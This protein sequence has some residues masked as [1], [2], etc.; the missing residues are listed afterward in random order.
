MVSQSIKST[1]RRTA[2]DPLVRL[3]GG[4]PSVASTVTHSSSWF[5]GFA[6]VMIGTAAVAG[7][8]MFFALK[9]ALAA[10][11][12]V[13]ATLAVLWALLILSLDRFMVLSMEGITNIFQ[14]T[15]AALPR[16]LLAL[17][18]G[19]V[20]SFPITLQIFDKEISEELV[21]LQQDRSKVI[22]Q[23]M[24][25]SEFKSAL[26]K[27]EE[28]FASN[29]DVRNGDLEI[30]ASPE[31]EKEQTRVNGLTATKTQQ[32]AERNFA[33]SVELCDREGP[34][35]S[36]PADV[37]A[38]CSQKPGKNP[39]W[40]ERYAEL[41]AK[42]SALD[43]TV[44]E[45]SIANEALSKAQANDA[46][47]ADDEVQRRVG[48]AQDQRAEL[49]KAVD[50][51]KRDYDNRYAELR[52]ANLENTGLI[53]RS[54]ALKRTA[55]SSDYSD[56]VRTLQL[57][58]AG[59][60]V[61]I[62][63][64]PV[65]MKLLS[66]RRGGSKYEQA[67]KSIQDT[68]TDIMEARLETDRVVAAGLEATRCRDEEGRREW[69]DQIATNTNRQMFDAASRISSQAVSSWASASA[70]QLKQFYSGVP[71]AGSNGYPGTSTGPNRTDGRTG[72]DYDAS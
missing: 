17:A 24:E 31:V 59:M 50:Q 56:G 55:T 60:F 39:P 8:S 53:M 58:V 11:L 22:N 51:A 20:V 35:A 38:Q 28:A 13:A 57:F 1:R 36:F 67:L 9:T 71:G 29:E 7:I 34:R 43:A 44:A 70:H 12:A 66:F 47:A 16:V 2:L 15:V 25:D 40:P 45:L 46:T 49:M 23:Q 18:I 54:M 41:Q 30:P 63:L 5:I 32:E 10:S 72:R 19:I 69:E 27:A 3:G 48:N 42:Q 62:E 6:L 21:K 68:E 61:A 4:E 37:Q 65:L 52:K 26:D 64:A 33:S 14:L